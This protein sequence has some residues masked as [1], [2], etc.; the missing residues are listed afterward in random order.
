MN[1]EA[2]KRMLT[3]QATPSQGQGLLGAGMAQQAAQARL[4]RPYLL[5]VKEMESLGQQPLTQEQFMQQYQSQTK[6]PNSFW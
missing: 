3:G 6:Q 5:H 1:L 2:L 4:N